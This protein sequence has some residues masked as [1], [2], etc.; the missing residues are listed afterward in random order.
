MQKLHPVNFC[1]TWDKLTNQFPQTLTGKYSSKAQSD[2][3]SSQECKKWA[4][5]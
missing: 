5:F 3:L 2:D 1:Q 4:Y